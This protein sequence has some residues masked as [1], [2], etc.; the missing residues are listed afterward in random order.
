MRER[1]SYIR[2]GL[3]LRPLEDPTLL[4]DRHQ[5]AMFEYWLAARDGA[6]LPLPSRID[7]VELPRGCLPYIMVKE[8]EPGTGRY[9]TRLT[10]TAFRDASGFDGTNLYSD[11]I[12]GNAGTLERFNWAVANRQPY[13]YQGPL[14]FSVFD[15]KKF[16]ALVL[17]FADPG[18]PVTRLVAVFDF[19]PDRET[20]P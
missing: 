1:A 13:W 18:Q 9:R 6:D 17:P 11:E 16:S 19:Q 5:R 12:L 8:H 14:S 20:K 3:W 2:E 4:R 7:P 15:Y 10:G